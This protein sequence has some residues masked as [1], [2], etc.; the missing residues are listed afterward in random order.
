MFV[1]LFVVLGDPDVTIIVGSSEPDVACRI[2]FL[3]HHLRAS[4]MVSDRAHIRIIM[5]CC[6]GDGRQRWRRLLIDSYFV[7]V[8]DYHVLELLS[9]QN[10]IN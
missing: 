9:M 1:S 6:P 10:K 4:L 5:D 7:F 3:L 2:H 8:I